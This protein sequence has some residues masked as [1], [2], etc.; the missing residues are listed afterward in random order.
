MCSKLPVTV[1]DFHDR[2]GSSAE[3][4]PSSITLLDW[5][6]PIHIH[7]CTTPTHLVR[8]GTRSDC[9]L[10]PVAIPAGIRTKS[11]EQSGTDLSI[12]LPSSTYSRCCCLLLLMMAAIAALTVAMVVRLTRRGVVVAGLPSGDGETRNSTSSSFFEVLNRRVTMK[13]ARL[14]E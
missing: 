11:P 6:G 4:T 9:H 2:N 12:T 8:S 10:Q 14:D 13:Q 7:R 3:I 5:S 1:A